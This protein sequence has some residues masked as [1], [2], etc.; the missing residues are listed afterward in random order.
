M[1]NI[2]TKYPLPISADAESINFLKKFNKKKGKKTIINLNIL[3]LMY[4]KK[5]QS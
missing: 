2:P 3:N 5:T 4:M 1:N